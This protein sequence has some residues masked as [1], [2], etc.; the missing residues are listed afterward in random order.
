[1]LTIS[2]RDIDT[3]SSFEIS[4]NQESCI[5]ELNNFLPSEDDA[6]IT[7]YTNLSTP[8]LE[9]DQ[10][11]LVSL[12]PINNHIN[13]LYK[14]EHRM[15]EKTQTPNFKSSKSQRPIKENYGDVLFRKMEPKFQIHHKLISNFFKPFHSQ[16][17]TYKHISNASN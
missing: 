15:Q 9:S 8:L 1:M 13:L 6:S 11:K 16:S 14:I 10:T 4:I 12:G 2:L 17:S 5:R 3:Y 7:F